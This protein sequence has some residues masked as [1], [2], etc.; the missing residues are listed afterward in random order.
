MQ[1]ILP[2]SPIILALFLLILSIFGFSS[3][4]FDYKFIPSSELAMDITLAVIVLVLTGYG[5][6]YRETITNNA[7]RASLLLPMIAALFCLIK[8][9][10]THPTGLDFYLHAV[11]SVLTILC[12]VLLY[13]YCGKNGLG[14]IGMGMVSFLMTIIF[15]FL[16][17]MALIVLW[18]FNAQITETTLQTA[19]SPNSTYAAEVLHFDQGT[20]EDN[21]LVKVT[22]Q[23]GVNLFLGKLRRD[24]V[25]IYMAVW[26]ESDV[27]TLRWETDNLLYVNDKA[28]AMQDVF[29]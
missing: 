27:T 14:R 15:S 3:M 23:D 22:P 1:K 7:I 16:L 10:V 19:L 12:G 18:I 20:P 8:D 29:P 25:V 13:I 5:L 17:I 6:K 11:F 9:V 4:Y 21:V 28:Y 24:T 26:N 2:S